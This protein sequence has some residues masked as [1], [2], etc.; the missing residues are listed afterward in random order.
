MFS[1]QI[2]IKDKLNTMY[3]NHGGFLVLLDQQMYIAVQIQPRAKGNTNYIE[4]EI[5]VEAWIASSTYDLYF[6]HPFRLS[7]IP[8]IIDIFLFRPFG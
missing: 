4:N 5:A 3:E 8:L 2:R 1:T 7:Y 6:I